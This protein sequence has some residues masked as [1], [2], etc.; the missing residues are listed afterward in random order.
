MPKLAFQWD[1]SISCFE[2]LSFN[3]YF[4]LS[5]FLVFSFSL[6]PT[7][8]K[9]AFRSDESISSFLLSLPQY[10]ES[11][12]DIGL[13]KI[14]IVGQNSPTAPPASKLP[15]D[16]LI[17]PFHTFA[18]KFPKFGLMPFLAFFLIISL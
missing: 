18:R 9:N 16:Q 15:V 3:F 4:Y 6:W 10:A 2:F 17:C 1:E 11:Q 14:D 5:I 13:H 12:L 7:M 8:P